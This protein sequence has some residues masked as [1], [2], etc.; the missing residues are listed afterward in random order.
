MM[1][2]K[3][4]AER[5][6]QRIKEELS[7]LLLFGV[8]D[9]RLEGVYTTDVR[10]DRE[11]AYANIFVSAVEGAERMD[12]I[13]DGLAH[14]SGYLRSQLAQRIQLRHFPRLRFNWDPTPEHAGR[15]EEL[16]ASLDEEK[17]GKPKKN[18]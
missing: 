17:E 2:S 9:P 15:I 11:M 13:M 18:E 3:G 4:R 7:E 16:I 10:I 6:S 5:V 12:E 8:S 1:V 14:A